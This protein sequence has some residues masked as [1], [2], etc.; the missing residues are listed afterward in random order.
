M[1][2][3]QDIH[4]PLGIPRVIPAD[5]LAPALDFARTAPAI[6]AFWRIRGLRL[7][8]TDLDWAAGHG[9]EVHGAGE[10]LLLAI[11]GRRGITDELNGPGRHTIARRIGN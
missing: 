7:L 3:Q 1:I 4:R 2:H 10:A 8:A 6:G 5:R 9:P 11:A